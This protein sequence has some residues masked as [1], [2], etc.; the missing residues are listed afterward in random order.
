MW[1]TSQYS[2]QSP[3]V[4]L[5]GAA[6]PGKVRRALCR[7]RC[8]TVAAVALS[9]IAGSSPP[10]GRAALAQVTSTNSPSFESIRRIRVIE[11]LAVSPDGRWAAYV[12]RGGF[13]PD[14]LVPSRIAILDLIGHGARTIA[15]RG[16][17]HAL[18]WA[19][20]R[21]NVLG[22][23]AVSGDRVG[24]WQL[25][26]LDSTSP[27]EPIGI[28]DSLEGEL[29]G[30]AWSPDGEAVAY[31]AADH[32]GAIG[33]SEVRPPAPRL[34]LFH[35]SPGDYT[36][37]T[38]RRYSRDSAGAYV[39]VVR[40]ADLRARVLARHVVSVKGVPSVSWSRAGTILVNGTAMRASWQS[41]LR[42]GLACTI[43]PS[44]GAVQPMEPPNWSRKRVAWSPSGKYIADLRL[45][46]LPGGHLPLS[47]YTLQVESAARPGVGVTFEGETD[48]LEY[49]FPPIWGTDD[50]T[51]YVA[52]NQRAT[53]RLFVVDVSSQE[54]RQI[55]PDTLSISRY[56]ISHDGTVLLGVL[57]NANQPQEVFRIDPET[58]TLTRL[59]HN[60]ED[61]PLMQL[62][63]VDQVAWRSRD[64][65]FTV[66][67]FL[68]KPY[69]YDSTRRYPL[70][71]MAHGGP[72]YP[73]T[74]NFV[75]VN[76]VPNQLPP[77]LLA[78]A[79]FM[80][81]LPNPRGD[82]GYGV[83]FR[84]ALHNDWGQGPF[85]DVDAGVDALI[86]RGV[87]D[88]NRVGIAGT[89]Y[90]GYLAAYAITQTNRYAA[91]SVDDAPVDL[92]SEY[93]QN[94]A[95]RSSWAKAAFDGTPWTR[96]EA[97]AS[98][99][100]IT[101]VSRVRTPVIMRYGGRSDTHD[102]IRQSYMLAQGFELYAGLRDTDVPV[103][104]VLH[105]DQGHGITDW[106]LYKDWVT[107]NILW[108][109]YWILHKGPA[110]AGIAP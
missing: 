45:D 31:L 36:G 75:G 34:V 100:P 47:R 107:R 90:G 10:S 30:F 50:R 53:A 83:E 24:I 15:V 55:T 28:S 26:P 8:S 108:L 82:P 94:Y 103:E 62:G 29:L 99:S 97:Y 72:G 78:A 20:G 98:Q 110:P 52:R 54:W 12:S 109:E 4:A 37:P 22:Y 21:R 13:Y 74:N 46:I 101:Y 38:S 42:S 61:V 41:R 40:L 56:A 77:Q 91:A 44:S 43:D 59:T 51:L 66:H 89:S 35:D 106:Y 84:E 1:G 32:Q 2:E 81:L 58:G 80:V 23:L 33:T 105:P 64:H 60:A 57:E 70:I 39:A 93:G 68:V 104:F 95:T 102:N 19:P 6:P 11:E 69:A 76:F 86:R 17:P 88:S 79:G 92:T 18:Q 25:S 3:R 65:R 71:V 14:T 27:P 67:G 96:H 49:V 48:G 5:A 9:V 73:F 63:H 16:N 87:V 85:A 7:P